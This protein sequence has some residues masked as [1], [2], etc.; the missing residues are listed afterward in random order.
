MNEWAERYKRDTEIFPFLM[1]LDFCNVAKRTYT[2]VEGWDIDV[3]CLGEMV[4]ILRIYPVAIDDWSISKAR[5]YLASY[6]RG[7]TASKRYPKPRQNEQ[8]SKSRE[9]VI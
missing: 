6:P 7:A 5:Y 1:D 8:N 3:L 9:N 2:S 4:G